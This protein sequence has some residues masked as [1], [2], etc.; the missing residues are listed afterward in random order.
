MLA[1][2]S[3][4]LFAI[5]SASRRFPTGSGG[6]PVYMFGALSGIALAFPFL[7]DGRKPRK[8]DMDRAPGPSSWRGAVV[9][10]GDVRTA[11]RRIFGRTVF[12]RSGVFA[13]F[14]FAREFGGHCSQAVPAPF[15]ATAAGGMVG[16][17]VA[18]GRATPF[19]PLRLLP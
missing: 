3:I 14:A 19:S 18:G 7:L 6:G 13:G 10:G 2:R 17:L 5:F 4:E 15:V 8:W 1:F 12:H 16:K 9:D 11:G